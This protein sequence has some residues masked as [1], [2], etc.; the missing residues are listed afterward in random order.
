[1][2][3]L[4]RGQIL[5]PNRKQYQRITYPHPVYIRFSSSGRCVP[6]EPDVPSRQPCLPI[7]QFWKDVL[8]CDIHTRKRTKR[9]LKE[10]G[11]NIILGLDDILTSSINGSGYNEQFQDKER[12]FSLVSPQ[13]QEYILIFGRFCICQVV[14]C[15]FLKL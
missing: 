4:Q 11:G 5:F 9:I 2:Q 15:F 6:A 10:N 7:L 8:L 1:M 14:F 3:C 12:M 13:K